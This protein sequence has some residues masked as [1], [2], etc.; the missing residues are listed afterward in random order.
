MVLPLPQRAVRDDAIFSQFNRPP[1]T[2]RFRFVTGIVL[3]S[4]FHSNLVPAL[5]NLS[6]LYVDAPFDGNVCSHWFLKDDIQFK[7][8]SGALRHFP[9]A[10]CHLVV[11]SF[12]AVR[13]IRSL[14]SLSSGIYFCNPMSHQAYSQSS[15]ILSFCTSPLRG[16]SALLIKFGIARTSSCSFDAFPSSALQLRAAKSVALSLKQSTGPAPGFYIV[17]DVW[18]STTIEILFV[19]FQSSSVSISHSSRHKER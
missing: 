18:N 9:A 14:I 11:R 15:R 3:D 5:W 16:N 10:N 6:S 17:P 1:L 2:I 7:G 4:T 19:F 8:R 12:S 13:P